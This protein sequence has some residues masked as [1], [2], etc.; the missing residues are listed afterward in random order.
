MVILW[1]AHSRRGKTLRQREVAKVAGCLAEHRYGIKWGKQRGDS[2]G[3]R[4]G[5]RSMYTY[6]K[7]EAK[8]KAE[9]LELR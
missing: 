2:E 5:E 9:L 1:A 8:A 7:R 4:E 3:E 6:S